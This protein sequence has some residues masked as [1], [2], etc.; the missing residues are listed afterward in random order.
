MT[1]TGSLCGKPAADIFKKPPRF[2]NKYQTEIC[3]AF[4]DVYFEFL[5]KFIYGRE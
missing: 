5:M 3:S 4:V 1:F 2:E